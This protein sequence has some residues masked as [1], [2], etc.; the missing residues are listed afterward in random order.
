M[1]RAD[2]TQDFS[3]SPIQQATAIIVFRH[4]IEQAKSQPR[5]AGRVG[6]LSDE[7]E[8]A[9]ANVTARMQKQTLDSLLLGLLCRR[10][11]NVPDGKVCEKL[12]TREGL[13]QPMASSVERSSNGRLR[14]QRGPQV[15]QNHGD[16][17]QYNPPPQMHNIEADLDTAVG[18]GPPAS[19]GNTTSSLPDLYPPYPASEENDYL[20]H[21]ADC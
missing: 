14:S 8:N 7:K 1:G 21:Q 4:V 10:I 16:Y 5:I 19:T 9:I 11:F 12:G 13:A 17:L 20:Y 15:G 3:L 6:E 2:C 18:N